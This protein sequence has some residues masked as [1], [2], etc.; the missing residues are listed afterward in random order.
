MN[1]LKL[2]WKSIL[3][4][5]MNHFIYA[6]SLLITAFISNTYWSIQT[7]KSVNEVIQSKE[8]FGTA[9]TIGGIIVFIFLIILVLYTNRF[10]ITVR[11]NELG[12]Y[13]LFGESNFSLLKLLFTEQ[14]LFVFTAGVVG[15]LL[16]TL[17]SKLFG[18]ILVRMMGY[19]NQ[20][21]INISP[22]P[23]LV[24]FALLIIAAILVTLFNIRRFSK[25]SLVS[26]FT[27]NSDVPKVRKGNAFLAF[28]GVFLIIGSLVY[29]T[30][31]SLDSTILILFASFTLG[32]ILFIN[33]TL[34]WY[35][36][37]KTR[38]K[39]YF[40][41][42]DMISTA[43]LRSKLP[44]NT[45][46]LTMI[47]LLSSMTLFLVTFSLINL[48]TQ[49]VVPRTH[50]PDDFLYSY[51]D[52]ATE[53]K[54]QQTFGGE[55]KN[56]KLFDTI[57][58][59]AR[60]PIDSAFTNSLQFGNSGYIM[61][62]SAYNKLR[63]FR[64]E[65]KL[66]TSLQNNEALSFSR[67]SDTVNLNVDFNIQIGATQKT[68]HVIERLDATMIGWRSDIVHTDGEKPPTFVVSDIY[69]SQAKSYDHIQKFS[70][71]LLK[72][73]TKQLER[74]K[75]AVSHLPKNTYYSAYVIPYTINVES[76]AL[77]LFVS[78]FFCYYFIYGFGGNDLFQTITRSLC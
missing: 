63:E 71:F 58:I 34:T 59:K 70:T 62:L 21:A 1:L 7:N 33:Q 24:S 67:G 56:H 20:V 72:E 69:Y 44:R 50:L 8:S 73:P 4:R 75:I 65:E 26:L 39:G 22:E 2:S 16:G 47:T 77:L 57:A 27:G 5:P 54:I 10:Y 78:T 11:E 41:K 14:L 74:I 61:S 46:Q 52:K 51:V 42:L 9:L 13:L 40:I 64:G 53:N 12:T 6:L 76:G 45:F 18:T 68:L 3:R 48:E 17:F 31:T 35:I 15:N 28:L 37:Y 43:S 38:S 32:V 23:I 25:I 30:Q 66:T 49:K 19:E 60:S 55:I 36:H 29:S